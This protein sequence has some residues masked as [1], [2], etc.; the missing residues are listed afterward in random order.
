MNRV[1]SDCNHVDAGTAPR[2]NP[3][4]AHPNSRWLL[5]IVCCAVLSFALS[6][7]AMGEDEVEELL[8]ELFLG[9]S[10]YPQEAG[11]IQF[12]S[13]FF[14][15]RVNRNDFEIPLLFEYGLTDRLQIGAEVPIGFLH[16]G[17]QEANGLGNAE[18]E[19]YWNVLNNPRSRWAAGVGFALGL[20]APSSEVGEEALIYEPFFVAYREFDS[21]AVNFSA[22]LEIEDPT[23]MAEETEIGGELA[24]A[25]IRRWEPFALLMESSV[26]IEADETSTRLAPAV[27]WQPLHANW[28]LGVSVPVGFHEGTTDVGVF[29]LFTLE[30]GGAD[31]GEY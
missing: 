17:D 26:E 7:R 9:E 16:S 13:G 2:R 24:V 3:H 22:G 30:F 27:Y 5:H 4:R 18:L 19:V 25:L 23:E 28:E 29:I 20:P 15:T 11:E 12:S 31:D 21:L 1:D 10:V 6:D 8:Q 14:S